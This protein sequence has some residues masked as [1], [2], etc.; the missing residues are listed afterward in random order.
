MSTVTE[1]DLRELKDLIN[2]KFEQI[3]EK[4]ESRYQS[5]DS[6]LNDVRFD[7]DSKLNDVRFDLDSKLNEVRG[8]LDGKLNEMKVDTAT[9]KEGQNGINKRLDNLDFIARSVI[10][11]VILALIVGLSKVLYP[12]LLG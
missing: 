1:N 12:N 3:N 5:L 7:L 6:K 9:L 10:G 2:S 4:I 8:D 11:G